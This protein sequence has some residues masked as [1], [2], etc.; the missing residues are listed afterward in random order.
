MLYIFDLGN[1]IVDIDFKRA[2]GVWSHLSGVPLAL[3]Q[4]RFTFDEAFE[5]HERGELT[6]QQFAA[7][8]CKMLEIN[9][10]YAQF[11]A[12]WQAIF[13]GVRNEV[14]AQMNALRTQGH[15]VVILSNTNN[16]HCEFWPEHYPQVTDA[17]DAVYLSQQMQMR[18]PEAKIYQ[19]VLEKEGV[20]AQDAIFFDDNPQNIEA[21]QRLGIKS[22]LVTGPETLR[23][24][25]SASVATH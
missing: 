20:T 21:A 15:R 19:T 25:F 5:Q 12:G 11:A 14:V 10:S 1:V 6:D 7:S 17:A 4:H 3:L 24:W 9:L 2:L 8:L 22:V 13:V 23:E 18:K 16:L